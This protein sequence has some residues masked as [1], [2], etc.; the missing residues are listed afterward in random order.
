MLLNELLS[1]AQI[2]YRSPCDVEVKNIKPDS[3]RVEEGELY[4]AVEGLHRDGHAY[5]GDAI[6][7]GACAVVVSKNAVR[8]GRIEPFACCDLPIIAVDDCREASARLYSAFCGN[9]QSK[10]KM[11]GVTGT[12]GKTTVSTLIYEIML[13][14]GEKCGLIGTLGCICH[15]ERLDFA[16][17]DEL[18]NMTTP[19][20]EQLYPMLSLMQSRGVSTVIM[21]VSSH[22]LEQARVAP[23]C[24]DI[25]IFTNL[26]E[27]HLDLHGDM[28]SYYNAKKKLFAQSRS[29]VISCDD[30]YGR[31]LCT[32]LKLPIATCSAEDREVDNLAADIRLH[33]EGG[34]EYKLISPSLRLRLRSPM[35]GKFN[36][37]NT[38]EASIAAI[39]LGA[40]P[41]AVKE[42]ISAFKGVPGRLERVRINKKCDLSVYIDYAHTPDALENLLGTARAI[43]RH[44][45]R[46]VLLFG[47]GGDRDRTK[48]A[49]MGKIASSMADFVI[50]TS[51]NSRSEEPS[52]II[53]DIMSGI[54]PDCH[55]TVI[56]NRREAIEYAVKNARRN[57]IILLAGKGHEKYEID[58][59]GKSYFC[60]G[61]IVCSLVDKYYG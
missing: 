2:S 45:Q 4:I 21:E 59:A 3:R 17:A 6:E 41:A 40:S 43:R 31:R 26:S 50:V 20:P 46:I 57:D 23:I 30:K 8:D 19:D 52:A 47:C 7:R 35:P 24:F 14:A 33:G 1:R 32:E 12:N 10:M 22:A 49:M 18:A 51:D 25:A 28:E 48:R 29:A 42:A 38:L 56:E 36:V 13:S 61:E 53:S 16:P 5:I 44:G 54:D 11:I 58:K 9:P 55:F 34:I 27:D 39:R 15:G 37:M 60:E